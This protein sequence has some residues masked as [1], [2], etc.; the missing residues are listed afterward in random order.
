MIVK[1]VLALPVIIGIIVSLIGVFL[2]IRRTKLG[3]Q[4]TGVVTGVNKSSVNRARVKINTESP[5]VRYTVKGQ[6]YTCPA[7]TYQQEGVVT[8]KKG[9]KINIRVSRRNPRH[10]NPVTKGA[11]LEPFFVF[12]G[13]FIIIAYIIMYVRYF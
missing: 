9:Q 12:G 10:F 7:A 13:I 1:I 4:T 11:V 3:I 2:Y 6:E 8:Y 5:I